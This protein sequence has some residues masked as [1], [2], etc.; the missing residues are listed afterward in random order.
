MASQSSDATKSLS[1]LEDSL[2]DIFVK[3]APFQLPDNVKEIIVTFAPW[4]S[5]I[6]ALLAIPLLIAALGFS[7]L[8]SPFAA[9]GGA[10]SAAAAAAGLIAGIPLLGAVILELL[11]VKGLLARKKSGWNL[12]FYATLASLLSNILSYDLFNAVIGTVISWYI[13]FQVRSYYK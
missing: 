12:A 6:F 3:K 4:L 5:L 7:A 1:K 11:S 9:L 13:L 8:L 2:N 10:R